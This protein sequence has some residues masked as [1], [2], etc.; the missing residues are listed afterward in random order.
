MLL[1]KFRCSQLELQSS[2]DKDS[3]VYD[4]ITNNIAET[5]AKH[6]PDFEL[7]IDIP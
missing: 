7:T 1:R 5:A 6:K 3:R 2:A 4:N